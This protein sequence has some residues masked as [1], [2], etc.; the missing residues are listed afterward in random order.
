MTSEL[1]GLVVENIAEFSKKV[2]S[3]EIKYCVLGE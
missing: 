2:T 3:I 1:E